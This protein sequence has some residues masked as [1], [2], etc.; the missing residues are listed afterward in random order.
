MFESVVFRI[1]F[2]SH[3]RAFKQL[4]KR[5][6]LHG[7]HMEFRNNVTTEQYFK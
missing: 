7:I 2:W 4:F 5:N 3:F 6:P 1:L